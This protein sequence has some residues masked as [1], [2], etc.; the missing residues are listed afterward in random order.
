MTRKYSSS[1]HPVRK[2]Y[3]YP[4][5]LQTAIPKNS[6]IKSYANLK[7]KNFS[8]DK[9]TFSGNVTVE[10]LLGH[11]GVLYKDIKAGG[12][13]IYPVGYTDSA[14]LMKD[15]HVDAR[16]ALT[17]VLNSSFIALDFQHGIRFLPI[18]T[19]IADKFV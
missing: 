5:I 4:D 13:T 12:G 9:L 16:V 7:S 11:Y 3:L 14:A 1:S 8:P 17:N 19:K 2:S 15:G 18:E 10:R 6:P